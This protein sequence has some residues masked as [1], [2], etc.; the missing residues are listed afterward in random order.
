M[1]TLFRLSRVGCINIS[2]VRS[3]IRVDKSMLELMY[4]NAG[5]FLCTPGIIHHVTA[6]NPACAKTSACACQF[7]DGAGV[8]LSTLDSND[9]KNPTFPDIAPDTG[10]DQFS[11]NPCTA[12]TE[13]DCMDVALCNIHQNDKTAEYFPIGTQD[14]ADFS[15]NSDGKL[16]ITYIY[17]GTGGAQRQSFVSLTCDPQQNALFTASGENPVGSGMYYFDLTSKLACYPKE[18]SSEGLSLSVGTIICIAFFSFVLLYFVI[19]VVFQLAVKKERGTNLIIH[20]EA[21]SSIPGLIMDG[22]MFI[23]RK[24]TLSERKKLIH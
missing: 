13:S 3:K 17:K 11:W 15:Y 4:P 14:T 20:K 16:Q 8:D 19:G 22:T 23:F 24:G 21:I 1:T 7:P 18:T 12:F 2:S 6:T 5:D 9:P 10:N